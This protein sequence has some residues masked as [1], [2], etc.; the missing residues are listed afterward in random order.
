MTDP[1]IPG[2]ISILTMAIAPMQVRGGGFSSSHG[3]R[4]GPQTM[5]EHLVIVLLDDS[6]PLVPFADEYLLGGLDQNGAESDTTGLYPNTPV[7]DSLASGGR[8][9]VHSYGMP[10]CSPMRAS[11]LS[12]VYPFRHGVGRAVRKNTCGNLAE[13]GDPTYEF[14]PLPDRLP[15]EV[16]NGFVGKVH[17]SLPTNEQVESGMWTGRPGQGWDILQPLHFDFTETVLRNLNQ[18]DGVTSQL[19]NYYEYG[20]KRGSSPPMVETLYATTNQV[21]SAID[22]LSTLGGQRGFLVLALS[23]THSPWGPDNFPPTALVNSQPYLDASGDDQA[24][25][26]Y[27]A[28]MEAIDS[29]LGRL[30]NSIPVAVREHTTFAILADNGPDHPPLKN[31]RDVYGMQ[32]G[33]VWDVLLD[34]ALLK[35]S[36]HRMGVYTPMIWYGPRPNDAQVANPGTKTRALV[37]CV[38]LHATAADYF[39]SPSGGTDGIS[40]LNLAWEGGVAGEELVHGR[41]SSFSETYKEN[42]EADQASVRELSFRVRLNGGFSVDGLFSLVRE[43]G[44]EDELYLLEDLNGVPVDPFEQSP[45]DKDFKYLD[46]YLELVGQLDSLLGS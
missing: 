41:Q 37:D 39:G 8:R 17:L 15:P 35:H 2:L 5:A 45:L 7:I 16:R 22:F 42:G 28:S 46:V 43:T 1:L 32:V 38:D 9:F 44:V 34:D 25:P 13:Y 23:A 18:N 40:F 29:E 12:G 14:L 4:P 30:M 27:M 6:P 19:G 3:T 21:D 31:G 24:W 11:L 10:V 26:T 33:A 36:A 20:Y